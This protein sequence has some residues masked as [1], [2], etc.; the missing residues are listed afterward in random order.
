MFF[1]KDAGTNGNGGSFNKGYSNCLKTLARQHPMLVQQH[2]QN[3]YDNRINQKKERY[4]MAVQ[5]IYV[6]C[7][8]SDCNMKLQ[9]GQNDDIHTGFCNLMKELNKEDALYSLSTANRLY[10]DKSFQFLE[11][12]LCVWVCVYDWL[13]EHFPFTVLS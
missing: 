5:C 12:C 7:T 4:F 1:L 6:T 13:L 10:G 9:S 11:V 3:E 2:T 8:F